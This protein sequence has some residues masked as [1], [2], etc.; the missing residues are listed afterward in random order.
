M[1]RNTNKFMYTF[2]SLNTLIRKIIKREQRTHSLYVK[3]IICQ[4]KDVIYLF[5]SRQKHINFLLHTLAHT[6]ARYYS[7]NIIIKLL[8]FCAYTFL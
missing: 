6:L 4:N 8:G 1:A 7:T 3:K 5:I 2:A